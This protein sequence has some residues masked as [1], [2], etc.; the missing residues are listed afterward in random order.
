[1]TSNKSSPEGK[2]R[3]RIDEQLIKN[4]W[5]KLGEYINATDLYDIDGTGYIEE[6]GTST[7]PVDY[8]LIVDGE[9]A[10]AIEAKKQSESVKGHFS[11]A[12]RYSKSVESHFAPNKTY[13]LPVVYVANGDETYLYE[14]RDSAPTSRL[15]STV[16]TP[17]GLIR[18]ITRDYSKAHAW[19]QN[20]PAEEFDPDLWQHQEECIDAVEE[21][22]RARRRRMLIKMATGSGKTR[23]AK[24]ISYR[25]LESGFADNILFIPDTRKL[26]DDAFTSFSGY[27]PTGVQSKFSDKYRIVNLREQEANRLERGDVVI[28]TLQKMY[29]LL[30]DDEIDLELSDF[31]CIITDECHRSV[32]ENEGY[33]AVFEQFDAI[34]IGLTAT[35]TQRTLSRF[36]NNLVYDYGYKDAVKDGNVVP[37]QMYALETEI[38]M[39]GVLDQDTGEYYSPDDLGTKVLVPDTH[40]KVGQEIRDRMESE[41][42]LTL[43]FARNDNHATQIVSDLRETVFSD[44]PDSYI[45]KITYKVDRPNDVLARFSDPYD[46]NP[47]IAVTVQ[48]VSTGVDIRPLKNVV[49]LNPVKSPVLFNQMLG[50]GT[51]VYAGKEYFNIFDCVGALEYFSGVPPFGTLDY[52]DQIGGNRSSSKSEGSDGDDGPAIVDVPDEIIRSEPVFPTET[53]ERLTAKGFRDAFRQDVRKRADEIKQIFDN[54]T[55]VESAIE[56]VRPVLEELSQYYVPIFLTKSYQPIIE[57]GEYLLIDYVNEALTGELPSFDER[58][59]HTVSKIKR[60]YDLT[61]LEQQ[62]VDLISVAAE[63]P[64]GISKNDFFDPPLSEIG[65]WKRANK[66]FTS[67]SPPELVSNFRSGLCDLI[68]EYENQGHTSESAVSDGVTDEEQT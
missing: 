33:G 17:K 45:K 56:R 13:G 66:K 5:T 3:D 44:R 28:T 25:L 16:H 26:A 65:G 29:H 31:D 37:F 52:D 50:R 32:Y 15:L 59:S 12:E 27:H 24:A 6:M 43:I 55:D 61:D 58:I 39:G 40:R 8:G 2:A 64:N 42:E 36:D 53:G 51:R 22:L 9:L 63:R 34:E 41:N 38:T 10:S 23:V 68:G 49:L 57:E 35:P 18:L 30:G 62:Y 14:F 1:M 4:G 19:L 54:S 7:G 46:S 48:M 20:K 21:T 60:S 47:A 11:Q 67:L